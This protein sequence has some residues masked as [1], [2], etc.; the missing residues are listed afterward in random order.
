MHGNITPTFCNVCMEGGGGCQ[1]VLY[2]E[3]PSS[4]RDMKSSNVLV[5]S[6]A[7][8]CVIGDLGLA[9][10]LIPVDNPKEIGNYGQA[11]IHLSLQLRLM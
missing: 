6:E 2:L 9:L 5:K 8:D 1:G 7:G 4:C 10:Q 11:R 3:M